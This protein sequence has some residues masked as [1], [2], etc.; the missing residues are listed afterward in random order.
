MD[1]EEQIISDAYDNGV[2]NVKDPDSELRSLL[3][4]A[5]ENTFRKDKRINIRLTSH[6]LEGIQRKA[7]RKGIPYQALISGLIHQYVE[8]ELQET[9][10]ANYSIDR[11]S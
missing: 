1:A 11:T 6:D 4:K 8:G 2:L 3:K 9:P 10:S 5:G 7:S